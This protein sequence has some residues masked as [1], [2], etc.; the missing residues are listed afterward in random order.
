MKNAL[1]KD[2]QKQLFLDG[3]RLLTVPGWEILE[4]NE[5]LAFKS[6]SKAP[7]IDF[8]YGP[9]TLENYEKAKKF[10]S[11]K[12]FLWL[13][14]AEQEG[15]KLA[16]LGFKGPE[17]SSE[18]IL[19]LSEYTPSKNPSNIDI[20]IADTTDDYKK[21][22]DVAAEWLELDSTMIE[23]FFTP[24]IK[25]TGSIPYLALLNGKAA[26]TSL[27][28]CDNQDAAIYC[29]GTSSAFRCQGLGISV[30]QACLQTAKN[31]NISRVVL[32]ASPMG[33]PLYEKI[34]FRV[35]QELYGYSYEAIN[36]TL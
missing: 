9:A 12:P 17:I 14:N 32:Y 11:S 28:Y 22:L 20:R 25:N 6:P 19:L 16:D 15:H 24:W 4:G 2:L 18:M 33:K 1:G 21:W 29:L 34:G 8:I 36:T 10:Y 7:F 23:D 31:K 3:M 30:T 26:A 5:I 27:L 13:L 35:V